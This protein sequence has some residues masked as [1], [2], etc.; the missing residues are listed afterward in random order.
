MS[1][2]KRED[3]GFASQ[4]Q[5]ASSEE[6]RKAMRRCHERTEVLRQLIADVFNEEHPEAKPL[7][8]KGVILGH[9]PCPVSPSEKC[10]Y[11]SGDNCIFCGK[12]I[13]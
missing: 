7:T 4:A 5:A 12:A 13:T 3:V 11:S 9:I 1:Y 2:T 6:A 10:V 8:G